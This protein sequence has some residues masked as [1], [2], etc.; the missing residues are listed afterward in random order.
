MVI[1]MNEIVGIKA[2]ELERYRAIVAGIEGMTDAEKD[3]AIQVVI[4]IM[5]AFVDAAWGVHPAQVAVKKRVLD[6]SQ[7]QREDGKL[8][9]LGTAMQ[10]D[11]GH[12]GTITNYKETEIVP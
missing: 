8:K 7:G 11:L 10:F 1:V 3:E 2:E 5:Q 6:S 9:P 4:N 12:E